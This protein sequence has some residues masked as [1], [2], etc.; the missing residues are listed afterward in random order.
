MRWG[1]LFTDI[2]ARLIGL[3]GLYCTVLLLLVWARN[4]GLPEAT[5]QFVLGLGIFSLAMTGLYL[6]PGLHDKVLR[7]TVRLLARIPFLLI[8][9]LWLVLIMAV[10]TFASESGHRVIPMEFGRQAHIY[11]IAALL[12]LFALTIFPF[13]LAYGD[14][15]AE[16]NRAR[17]LKRLDRDITARAAGVLDGSQPDRPL[18]KRDIGDVLAP[19]PL[20]LTLVWS[21]YALRF[22]DT[23]QTAQLDRWVEANA[24][25]LFASIAVLIVLPPLLNRHLRAPTTPQGARRG[26]GRRL[27]LPMLALPVTTGLLLAVLPH[28]GLPQAW[29]MATANPVETLHYK[30]V[31]MATDPGLGGCVRL[32]PVDAPQDDMLHCGMDRAFTDQLAPGDIFEATGE[33][34]RFGHTFDQ[35]RVLR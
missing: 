35:V 14:A 2:S 25:M 33:L 7:S 8:N 17:L 16:L 11:A 18:R 31:D 13:G 22:G 23:V 24:V 34:S 6:V 4:A 1:L 19:L 28:D 32:A 10:L 29:N 30:L 20:G 15:R 3:F 26:L 12:G 27:A 9:A 21:L 5:G